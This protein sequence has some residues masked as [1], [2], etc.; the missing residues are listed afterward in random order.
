MS[1]S[2]PVGWK[3]KVPFIE[4]SKPVVHE[5][6]GTR[7]NFFPS[8]I[9]CVFKLKGFFKPLIESVVVLL[10]GTGQDQAFVQKETTPANPVMITGE[11][12]QVPVMD[13]EVRREAVHTEL[14]ELRSK[15]KKDA[16]AQIMNA[17]DESN[18]GSIGNLIM[19]SMK[20]VFPRLSQDNPPGE[21]FAM[22]LDAPVMVEMLVGVWKANKGMF[23]PLGGRISAAFDR[24]SQAVES[25]A[26]SLS[27]SSSSKTAGTEADSTPGSNYKINS[28][29]SRNEDMNSNT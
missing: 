8:S 16:V 20:E 5:V 22:A 29:G 23:G 11:R 27:S 7:V 10:E 4:G 6:Q 12:G 24:V 1:K 28:A 2:P 18:L 3:A 19:D 21:E 13:S 9:G 26:S 15:K 17:I 25:K 14:A